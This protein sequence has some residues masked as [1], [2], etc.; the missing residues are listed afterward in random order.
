IAQKVS[1]G[2]NVW[3]GDGVIVEAGVKIGN[4]VTIRAGS[5]V[6]G[7]IKDGVIAHGNPA[8]G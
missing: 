5:V 6:V 7:D 4:D 8:F 1:V 2:E 3:I